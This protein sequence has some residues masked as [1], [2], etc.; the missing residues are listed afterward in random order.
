MNIFIWEYPSIHFLQVKPIW[1][2]H[3]NLTSYQTVLLISSS[4]LLPLSAHLV[5]IFSPLPAP[6]FLPFLP[7]PSIM[8]NK[9]E[10][11]II[12]LV[13]FL[14]TDE[15]YLASGKQLEW[16]ISVQKDKVW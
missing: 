15:P 5:P 7:I 12:S 10:H 9:A 8:L 3:F 1:L 4:S 2:I 6:S 13:S 14:E 16:K 11:I